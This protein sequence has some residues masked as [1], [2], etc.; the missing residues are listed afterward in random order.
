MSSV[1]SRND[2]VMKKYY[3]KKQA[4]YFTVWNKITRKNK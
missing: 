3:V 2:F 4:A 1:T